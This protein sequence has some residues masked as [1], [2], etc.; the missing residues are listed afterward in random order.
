VT[1]THGFKVL[2][3]CHLLVLSPQT[4][5]VRFARPKLVLSDASWNGGW[6]PECMGVANHQMDLN[7]AHAK[8]DVQEY[9]SS[10]LR[11]H[12]LDPQT[13]LQLTGAAVVRCG[14]LS[15]EDA[16]GVPVTVVASAGVRHN[17]VCAGD[18]ASYEENAN[19]EFVPIAPGT[20]NVTVFVQ[21]RLEPAVLPRLFTVVA[22][23]KADLLRERQVRS[24][25]SSR[26]ATG[27]GT[28]STIVVSDS[29]AS[30]R[31]TTG[32]THSALGMAVARAARAAIAQALG[33]D[34]AD[35]L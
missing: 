9:C 34:P 5:A 8:V 25:Y 7:T 32:S 13:S 17:A 16:G 35:A 28:D 22:E 23:A 20:I 2:S 19:N 30:R 3:D 31:L 12:N 26:I 27:T 18:Q 33:S 24:C 10:L 15:C 29:D 14:G 11:R 4:A 6:L 21:A 1:L